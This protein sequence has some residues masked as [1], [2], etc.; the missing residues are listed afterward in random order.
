MMIADCVHLMDTLLLFTLTWYL[1]YLLLAA[2]FSIYLYI[3]KNPAFA[4][5]L[6]LHNILLHGWTQFR[7]SHIDV[8]GH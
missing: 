5:I 4:Y 3:N 6:Y 2:A 8:Y 7:E 1:W